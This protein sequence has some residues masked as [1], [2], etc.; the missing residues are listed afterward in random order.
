MQS[1]YLMSRKLSLTGRFAITNDAGIPQFEVHGR[2][3]PARKLSVRDMG[4]AEVAVI[5]RRGLTRRYLILADGQET[6]VY[7]RGLFGK[8][9]EIDTPAGLMEARGNFSGRQYSITRGGMSA[10]AVTQLRTLREQ[11]AVEVADGQNAVL[12][13]AVVLVIETIRNDHRSNGSLASV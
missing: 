1:T 8:R 11:F 4:G 6:A 9:F 2:F 5:S 10:A 7:S 12:M 3:G 13:L